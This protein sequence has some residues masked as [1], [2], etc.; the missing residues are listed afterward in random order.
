MAVRMIRVANQSTLNNLT[1]LVTK[2]MI[3]ASRIFLFER[4]TY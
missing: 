1:D 3:S 4:F 2:V